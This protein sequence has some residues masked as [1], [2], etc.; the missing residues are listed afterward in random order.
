MS[1]G[2]PGHGLG[3]VSSRRRPPGSGKLCAMS[4]KNTSNGASGRFIVT[5]LLAICSVILGGGAAI[6][7]PSPTRILMTVAALV[8]VA[9]TGAFL[10]VALSASRRG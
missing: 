4:E 1:S 6:M 5:L 8:F 3:T 7:D 10:G 2:V 9:L